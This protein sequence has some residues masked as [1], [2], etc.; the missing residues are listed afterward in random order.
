MLVT[1]LLGCVYLIFFAMLILGLVVWLI[2][3]MF[4]FSVNYTP[5]Q[6][7]RD[8]QQYFDQDP[9]YQLV[10]ENRKILANL[11]E[12][13][14]E[15]YRMEVRADILYGFKE[16][17]PNVWRDPDF[18]TEIKRPEDLDKNEAALIECAICMETFDANDIVSPL[19]CHIHHL[20]HT[21]CIRPWLLRNKNC[22]LC[23]LEL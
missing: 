18:P 10:E 1:L 13:R 14:F 17:D 19:P 3:K 9:T 23:K 15:E 21:S 7:W 22:P 4:G 2:S 8:Q 5:S 20:F 11:R 12:R 16:G 6:L